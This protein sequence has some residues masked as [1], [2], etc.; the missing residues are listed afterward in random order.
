MSVSFVKSLGAIKVPFKSV[1]LNELAAIG[2]VCFTAIF[3]M[4]N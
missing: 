3:L 1:E 4:E 2:L